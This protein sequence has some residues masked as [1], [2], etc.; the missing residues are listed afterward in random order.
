M[1]YLFFTFFIITY[2]F[3]LFLILG[4]TSEHDGLATMHD[5]LDAKWLYDNH[6]DESYLRKVIRPL[7]GLLTH[8]KRIVMKDSAV[9]ITFYP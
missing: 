5:I 4:F 9:R 8:Y 6:R 2:T 1:C 3:A 7:E